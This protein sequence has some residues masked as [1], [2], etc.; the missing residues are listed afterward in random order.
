[1]DLDFDD[2]PLDQAAPAARAGARFKPK[3]RPQPKKKQVSLSTSQATLST[4]V[5]VDASSAYP[6]KVSTS[7]TVVPDSG[8]INQSTTIGTISKENVDLFSGRVSWCMEPS[9]LRACT[10]NVDLE[11]KRC[12]DGIDA[13]PELPDEPRTQDS[14]AFGD[15]V[16]PETD[17]VFRAQS[18]R[19]QTEEAER[20]LEMESL[21]IVQEDGITRAY[22]QHTGKFQPKPRLLDTV[23]E[24]PESHY[25]VDDTGYC[26]TATNESEF[27]VN[28]ESRNDFN[29][30]TREHQE[31][32]V[33]SE[34]VPEMEAQNASGGREHEEQAVSPRT[35]STVIGEEENS[36]G[37]TVEEAPRRE[38]KKG[39]SKGA[40]SRKRKNT[41]KE[42]PNKTSED[43]QKKK[44]KH[45][46]RRQKKRSVEKELLETPDDEIRYLPIKDMLRLVEYKEWMEKKEAKGAAVVPPT[47]ES[48]TNASDNQYYS[49]GFDAEDGFG[50]EESEN[51]ETEVVRPDSPVNYQTYMNK[52]SRTRWSKQDTELFYEVINLFSLSFEMQGIREFGSNLSMVQ[53]LFHDRTREQIKLKFK[54]EERRYPLK[55]NDALSSRSKNLTHYRNVIKKLQQEAAA[56]RE[57]AEEEEEAGAE[58]ETTTDVP[59]NEEPAKSEESERADDG[60][61]GVKES[62]GGDIENEVRSDGEGEDEGD[63]DFW[64]S[65]KSEM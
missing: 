54:L 37:N 19:M 16:T 48:N 27:M 30:N 59:D 47:Q 35:N 56:A 1:M 29:T 12:D 10:N 8:T 61:S 13:A 62:D 63:D 2:Q 53:Q 55:L 43:P 26:T 25:S 38:S 65:Y 9:A 46:S 40:T 57:E 11:G 58:A 42:D 4:D 51:Q 28:V 64:N 39:T 45:A 32:E 49:Q 60:I 14:A 22:E 31:E 6:N 3:G 15:S 24:E 5:S 44:F 20:H 21:D 18:Q 33:H 36:L 50:L 41:S 23:I 34:T 17:E 52:T 7:E